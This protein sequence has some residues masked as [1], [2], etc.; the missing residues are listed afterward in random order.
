MEE[1][2]IAVLDAVE[3]HVLRVDVLET[4]LAKALNLLRPTPD[5]TEARSRTLRDELAQLDGEVARLAGAIAAGGEMAALLA[6]LQEREQ[7]RGRVRAELAAIERTAKRETFDIGTVLDQMRG[8]LTDWPGLLRQEAPQA[9]Q[10]LNALLAGRLVFT[11]RE[12]DAG[13]YYEFEGPGTLGNVLAG[14]VLP[15]TMVTPG[16][17]DDRWGFALKGEAVA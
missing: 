17:A 7:R 10:A 16:G 8:M 15:K 11:P 4:A 14:L 2:D 9:R 6:A 13:R 12:Q 5:T 3:R 1:T